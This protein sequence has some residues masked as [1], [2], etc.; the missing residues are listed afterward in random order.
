MT[1]ENQETP[2]DREGKRRVA[3]INLANQPISDLA[4]AYFIN[5]DES[6]GKGVDSAAH[7]Y[8]YDPRIKNPSDKAYKE[9]IYDELMGSRKNGKRYTGN[10]SEARIIEKAGEI[11]KHSLERIKVQDILRL[12][13]SDAQVADEYRDRYMS[14][15]AESE[16]EEDQKVYVQLAS[17]YLKSFIDI[18]A[19]EALQRRAA[20]THG[21]LESLLTGR[22]TGEP[23][24][25]E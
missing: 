9:L 8:L 11:I 4:A 3:L 5:E 21:G 1:N 16:N 2:E 12:I 22:E 24:Q 25:G 13:G 19:G 14:D 15:L 10:V 6:Y 23:E 7:N 18:K 17:N 20:E